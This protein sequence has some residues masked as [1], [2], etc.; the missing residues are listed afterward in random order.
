MEK[1]LIKMFKQLVK[2]FDDLVDDILY[3]IVFSSETDNNGI[4]T[5]LISMTGII[6]LGWLIT[7]FQ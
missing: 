7:L 3:K 4:H 1:F 6:L 2:K 5:I